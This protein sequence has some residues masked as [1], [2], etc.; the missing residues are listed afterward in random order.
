MFS[1]ILKKLKIIYIYLIIFF[2]VI[3]FLFFGIG[4]VFLKDKT[5]FQ[6]PTFFLKSYFYWNSFYNLYKSLV[7][8]T[9]FINS[10]VESNY[11]LKKQILKFFLLEKFYLDSIKNLDNFSKNSNKDLVLNILLN[12][13][14]FQENVLFFNNICFYFTYFSNSF[15]QKIND[16]YI[17]VLFQKLFLHFSFTFFLDLKKII[18]TYNLNEDFFFIH[19]KENFFFKK[20]EITLKKLFYFNNVY[21]NNNNNNNFP[22]S[23]ITQFKHID[24]TLNFFSNFQR[25]SLLNLILYYEYYISFFFLKK[26]PVSFNKVKIYLNRNEGLFIKKEEILKLSIFLNMDFFNYLLKYKLNYLLKKKIISKSNS[27]RIFK[28]SF[29]FLKKS[30]FFLSYKLFFTSSLKLIT[31]LSVRNSYFLSLAKKL[32]LP[33]KETLFFSLFDNNLF[34]FLK[35]NYNF[36]LFKNYIFTDRGFQRKYLIFYLFSKNENI[37]F[38]QK[39]NV[40]LYKNISNIFLLNS[41]NF[42]CKNVF[43]EFFHNNYFFLKEFFNFNYLLYDKNFY[44]DFLNLNQLIFLHFFNSKFLFNKFKFINFNQFVLYLLSSNVE[45]MFYRFMF[46]FYIK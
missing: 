40:T 19:L 13:P 9:F 27:I 18:Y 37:Q 38:L 12:I 29:N 42:Y 45:E 28:Q 33:I 22:F 16:V 15:L 23:T 21:N 30:Y 32:N 3:S 17:C 46:S 6:L 5:T 36:D 20:K 1:Y 24:F 4:N 8:D 41:F 44:Y 10:N 43:I 25:I 7:S 14:Y 35:R 31:C 39:E 26:F 34:I 2:L 11:F